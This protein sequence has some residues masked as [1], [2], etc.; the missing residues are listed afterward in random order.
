MKQRFV[1]AAL[2]LAAA[3]AFAQTASPPP[4]LRLRVTV[5]SVDATSM[6]V[7]ER[8]GEVVKLALDDKLTVVSEV[9][10][11][12]LSALKPGAYIGTAAMPRPD[13][14]LEALEV[15]VF[16]ESA[17]GTGEGHRPWDLQPGSTMTNATVAD[18]AAV[19]QGRRLTLTY[20]DGAKTLFVPESAPVVTFK[21]ADRSLLVP[22]ARLVVT[23]E[24]RDGRP[25]A[26]RVL[27]GRNG[28][29]PPL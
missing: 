2:S 16:P 7:K 18:L 29:V 20:K 13:G 11:I 27:A 19:P 22:G 4:P 10:P 24:L 15:L 28:Y 14:T 1:A 23:A 21:P 6:T 8:S 25:T 17:R 9:L 26:L 5:E 3:L 12:E